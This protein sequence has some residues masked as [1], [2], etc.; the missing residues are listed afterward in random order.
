MSG[1]IPMASQI[2]LTAADGHA[3]A[4]DVLTARQADPSKFRL[5]YRRLSAL[6]LRRSNSRYA[7]SK[8]MAPTQPIVPMSQLMGL[9]LKWAPIHLARCF[10]LS[11]LQSVSVRMKL[12]LCHLIHAG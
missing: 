2:R 3:C 11:E 6:V 5:K 1:A 8:L 4:S 7:V 10:M 12:H 9:R